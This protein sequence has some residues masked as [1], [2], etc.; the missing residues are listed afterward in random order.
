VT[1]TLNQNSADESF[2]I[3]DMEIKVPGCNYCGPAEEVV[4]VA[5][6]STIMDEGV[7]EPEQYWD[8]DCNSYGRQE[9]AGEYMYGGKGQCGNGHT[10]SR[11]WDMNNYPG[12]ERVEFTGRI[13]TVES[14]DNE[15]FTIQLI[16]GNGN[17]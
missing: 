3:A 5:P 7:E 4:F 1:T 8:N 10:I 6:V 9:C 16:D 11:Q 2:G 12:V 17:V 13:F 14:W 15:H